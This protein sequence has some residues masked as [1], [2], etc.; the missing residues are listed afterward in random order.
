MTF[1]PYK[2]REV[3]YGEQVEVYRNL[4]KGN[5]SIRQFGRIVGHADNVALLD[6]EF[7]VSQA[8]RERVLRERQKNVHAY[9]VGRLES[10]EKIMLSESTSEAYYNPYKCQQFVDRDTMEYLF[11]AR[12]VILND[13]HKAYY[14]KEEAGI[15]A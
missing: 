11:E 9:I 13:D 12:V 10:F 14:V 7:R 5:W 15:Y 8:G 2:D 1:T 4:H 6:A 3:V